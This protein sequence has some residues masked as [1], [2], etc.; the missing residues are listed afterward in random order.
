MLIRSQDKKSLVNLDNI[1]SIDICGYRVSGMK[2]T[3]DDENA[4]MWYLSYSGNE[5]SF[6]VGRYS[7]ASK[8]IRVLDRIQKHVDYLRITKLGGG[9]IYDIDETFQIPL[10]ED[11]NE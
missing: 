3:E 1:E 7:T 4:N 10:D 6:F 11:V 5:K 2:V 8:A 9:N